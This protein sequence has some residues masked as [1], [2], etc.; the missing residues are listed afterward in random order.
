MD[1]KYVSVLVCVYVCICV[2][3]CVCVYKVQSWILLWNRKTENTTPQNIWGFWKYLYPLWEITVLCERV[4]IQKEKCL[5][6]IIMNGIFKHRSKRQ[7]RVQN[8]KYLTKIF[9]IEINKIM[10][11]DVLAHSRVTVIDNHEV[12]PQKSEMKYF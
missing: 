12:H 1:G 6:L 9:E 11:F 4:Q 2:C 7:V 5:V 10:R 3:V 8:W